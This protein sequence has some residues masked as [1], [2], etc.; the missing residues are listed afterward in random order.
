L[1]TGNWLPVSTNTPSGN[2]IWT[3]TEAMAGRTKRFY[4]SGKLAAAAAAVSVRPETLRLTNNA[5]GTITAFF[6]GAPVTKYVV[7]ATDNLLSG[8]W[9]NV[10]TNTAAENGCWTYTESTTGH[11]SRFYRSGVFTITP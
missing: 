9:L 6:R 5:D 4:R 7:Q 1:V 3:Y 8:V 11:P 2:G 10:S